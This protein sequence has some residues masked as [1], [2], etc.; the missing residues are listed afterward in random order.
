MEKVKDPRRV[1][2]RKRLGAISRGSKGAQGKGTAG[3]T[4]TART[5]YLVS[6]PTARTSDR[7][8]RTWRVLVP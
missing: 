3:I 1:E 4:T 7:S 8:H 5:Q 6:L 2:L